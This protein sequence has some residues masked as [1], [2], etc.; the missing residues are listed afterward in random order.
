M[1]TEPY[2]PSEMELATCYA[3]VMDEHAGENYDKARADAERGIAKIRDDA[4]APFV[5]TRVNIRKIK[6]D[7]LREAAEDMDNTDDPDAIH[8]HNGDIDLWLKARAD[9]I[10]EGI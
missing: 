2:V 10:E 7:A 1:S 9:R 6:A 3:E 8:V 5:L 4:R